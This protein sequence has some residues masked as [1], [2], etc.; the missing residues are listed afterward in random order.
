[1]ENP[2]SIK[3]F[4]QGMQVKDMELHE[5]VV[6]SPDPLQIKLVNNEKMVLDKDIL[7]VPEHLTDHSI[8]VSLQVGSDKAT[9]DLDTQALPENYT[10]YFMK[11]LN[12]PK[13][14][15]TLKNHLV[16]DEKVMLLSYNNGKMYYILDRVVK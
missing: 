15:L 8:E 13:G 10:G 7:V 14:I 9:L 16:K 2:T 6:V 4:I 3:Q 1:M 5:G 12:L 11:N